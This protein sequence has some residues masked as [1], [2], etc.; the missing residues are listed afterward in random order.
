MKSILGGLGLGD[1]NLRQLL[2]QGVNLGEQLVISKPVLH[3]LLRRRRLRQPQYFFGVYNKKFCIIG[4]SAFL[5]T[6]LTNQQGSDRASFAPRRFNCHNSPYDLERISAVHGK[7][8]SGKSFVSDTI[9]ELIRWGLILDC[10]LAIN[11]DGICIH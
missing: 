7:R 11:A 2:T 6:V 8:V 1:M 10:F 4:K 5:R 9:E 3:P